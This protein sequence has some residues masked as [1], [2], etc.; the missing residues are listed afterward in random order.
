MV[1]VNEVNGQILRSPNANNVNGNL[2]IRF[3]YPDT[4][5][6]QGSVID[7]TRSFKAGDQITVSGS[8]FTNSQGGNSIN[9][10]ARFTS[11]GVVQFSTYNP[12]TM[13]TAGDYVT[14]SNA[15]FADSNTAGGVTYVDLGGTYQ[16]QSVNSNSISLVTPASI[17][18]D[19][20]LLTNYANNRTSYRSSTFSLPV[21][22]TGYNVDGTYTVLSVNAGTI[23]LANPANVN[24]AWANIQGLPGGATAY[25]SP[26]LSTSGDGWVGPFVVNMPSAQRF[27]LNFVALQG[28]YLISKKGKDRPRSVDVVAEISPCNANGVTTGPAET[29]NTTV[30]GDGKDKNPKGVTL[31]ANV[32]FTGR[33]SVRLRR[34]TPTDLDSDDTI[35]DEVKVR[36]LYGL[37]PIADGTDFGNVTTVFSRT[38]ATQGATSAKERR[39]NCRVTRKLLV[40]NS[41]NTFGPT[42]MG[43]RN[44]ADIICHMALDPYI[45][46]RL[47][48][49]LDV[50]QIYNTV[51]AVVDYFGVADTG[52]FCYTFDQDNISFEEM[53][54]SVAQAVFCTAYRQGNK[55]RLFFEKQTQDSTLLFNHRNKLPGSETRTV[56]FGN[57]NDNDGVELEYVSPTDGA[58]LT[59]YVPEDRTAVK[60]KQLKIIGVQSE[61]QAMLQ[62]KRAYNKIKYQNT[63]TQF[64]ALGEATQ[65][66]LNERVEITDN[67]RP[68]V[69]D[70]HIEAVN[71]LVLQLTQPF[72][73]SAGVNYVMF[74][75]QV[76]GVEVIPVV[77]GIDPYHVVLQAPPTTPV[78]IDSNAW[79]DVLYQI[80][81]DNGGRSSGFLLSEKGSYDRQSLN[82]KAINYDDRYYQD[83]FTYKG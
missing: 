36:D 18:S 70:G 30:Y 47:L 5:E 17:N 52:Q 71:G 37:A 9:Q 77:A 69:F 40:R 60:A 65:L 31:Y 14:I 74:I 82:L 44:A 6:R 13:F 53:V 57:F 32:S 25:L 54:Q 80:I 26:S 58:K 38:Y 45:G 24:G 11:S 68:D 81:G 1:R 63:T 48:S 16:V 22:T 67:T 2:D 76:S 19:W 27:A 39:L 66:V 33:A 61:R 3:K 78:V 12:T 35:V 21:E 72:T 73:P 34:L 43:S 7:F 51:A 10:T 83:D 29:F 59:V 4:I 20:N 55:L 23:V 49:E 56:R 46:G 15:G 75:Q 50:A 28:M 62:A 8:S 42:L 79:A 64:D 41:D